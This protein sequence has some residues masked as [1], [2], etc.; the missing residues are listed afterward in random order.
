MFAA[1]GFRC[2]LTELAERYGAERGSVTDIHLPKWF[3]QKI[4]AIH[5]PLLVLMAYLHARNLR[6]SHHT[7]AAGTARR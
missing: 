7:P 4:P 2:P 6:R 1:N 5:G 3:A